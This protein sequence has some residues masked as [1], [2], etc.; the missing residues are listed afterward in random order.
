MVLSNSSRCL[1]SA[2]LGCFGA[3]AAGGSWAAAAEGGGQRAETKDKA[4]IGASRDLDMAGAPRDGNA[5]AE[6]HGAGLGILFDD[7]R[8]RTGKAVAWT[9]STSGCWLRVRQTW[10]NGV[11]AV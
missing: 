2:T 10:A 8:D 7:S 1:A 4:R 9:A 6:P 5:R 3:G 11:G